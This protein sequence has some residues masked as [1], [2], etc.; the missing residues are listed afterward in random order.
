[1]LLA[2]AMLVSLWPVAWIAS[3][4]VTALARPSSP[5]SNSASSTSQAGAPLAGSLS[6]SGSPPTAAA[7]DVAGFRRLHSRETQILRELRSSQSAH[8]TPDVSLAE[9]ASTVA[10]DLGTWESRNSR[11]PALAEKEA[12]LEAAVATRV[13]AFARRPSP[14]GVDAINRAISAFNAAV[15]SS[16]P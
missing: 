13:A 16:S 4:V 6:Q 5:S 11:A 12:R 1:M 14:A 8:G 10:A 7:V 3:G 9:R 15:P 2:V